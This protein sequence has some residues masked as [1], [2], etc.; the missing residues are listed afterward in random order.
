[1]AAGRI[2]YIYDH[3]GRI[4]DFTFG[5][6]LKVNSIGLRFDWASVPQAEDLPR[7]NRFAI[8]FQY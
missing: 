1:M 6:G 8:G 2:G 3:E 5:V 4:E 7:V